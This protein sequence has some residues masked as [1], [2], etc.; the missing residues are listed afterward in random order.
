M[1]K[2]LQL[3]VPIPCREN[4]DNMTKV[5]KG[6]FCASCQKQVIDF[7]TM[8]D[9][10]IA[11]FF[12]KPILSL[13]KDGS[14]C[15]RFMQHQLERPIEIPKKRI[16]WVKYFFQITIPFFLASL[17]AS[18]QGNVVIKTNKTV[19]IPSLKSHVEIEPV[20]KGIWGDTILANLKNSFTP[21]LEECFIGIA[22][23]VS[24]RIEKK[25]T[26]L[27]GRVVNQNGEAIPFASVAIKGTKTMTACD[28]AGNFKLTCKN[29]KGRITLVSSSVGFIPVEKQIDLVKD[30]FTDIILMQN[31]QVSG[32]VVVTA[33]TD[34]H[35]KGMIAGSVS[36]ISWPD[37]QKLN[38]TK[39]NQIHVYPNPA[40]TNT[41]LNIEWKQSEDRS[42][43][44]QLLN[45]SGQ[46]TF[47]K[48]IWID[49]E[50]RVLN[51]QLPSV[52]AGNYFLRMINKKSGKSYTEKIIIE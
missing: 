3:S 24:F 14:V 11:T 5:E 22:G 4:W 52:A 16:P 36:I 12:K 42:Y 51:I 46:L 34:R 1:S 19:C 13:S 2:Q 44:L 39:D 6:K 20:A 25:S 18:A 21:K 27:V 41:S 32:E 10:E 33:Y 15:G 48:E 28:S 8:S 47:T 23:A 9:R 35:I 38:E 31:N 17:K 49:D 40:K 43:I 45:Q 50:A 30:S 7:S 29:T 37:S 26:L